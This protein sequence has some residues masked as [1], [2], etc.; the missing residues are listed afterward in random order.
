MKIKNQ[1][2]TVMEISPVIKRPLYFVK[3][4]VPLWLRRK[5][6]RVQLGDFKSALIFQEAGG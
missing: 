1:C 3:R 2:M 5:Q 6:G 4:F